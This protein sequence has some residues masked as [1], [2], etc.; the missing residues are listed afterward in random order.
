MISL[1]Q[2]E[3]EAPTSS[4]QVNNLSNRQNTKFIVTNPDE[5]DN[6]QYLGDIYSYILGAE[7]GTL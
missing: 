5:K 3:L 4:P 7:W 2:R 6:N 1:K